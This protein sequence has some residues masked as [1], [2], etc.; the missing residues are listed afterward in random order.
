[1]LHLYWRV[2]LGPDVRKLVAR[3]E[4]TL[5][6]LPAYSPDF[7]PVELLF[8]KIKAFVKKLRPLALPDLI[9]AFADAVLSVSPTD[10]KNTFVHCGYL[11]Q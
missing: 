6:H 8:S 1:M 7:N 11:A 3:Y 5:L 4:R 9:Q 2:H 10:A